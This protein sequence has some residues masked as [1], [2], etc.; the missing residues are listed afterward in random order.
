METKKKEM[1]PRKRKRIVKYPSICL[2]AKCL[3]VSR[4]HLWYV[5]NG[6]RKGRAGLVEAYELLKTEEGR[7]RFQKFMA[8]KLKGSNHEMGG[9]V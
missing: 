5:L 4:I 1:R 3:G 2:A 7:L 6:E 9:R 8:E